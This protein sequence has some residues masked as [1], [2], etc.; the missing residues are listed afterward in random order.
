MP[1]NKQVDVP[2]EEVGKITPESDIEI[3]VSDDEV[4]EDVVVETAPPAEAEAAEPQAPKEDTLKDRLAQLEKAEE[5][6]KKLE[7]DLAVE[8]QRSQEAMRREAAARQEGQRY[9]GDA[10]EARYVAILNALDASEAEAQSAAAAWEKAEAEGDIKAKTDANRRLIRAE[11][12]ISVHEE[13]KRSYEAA[14]KE[15]EAAPP[16]VQQPE[17]PFEAALVHYPN[18]VR[19]WLRSHPEYVTD[20]KK[21]RKIATVHDDVIDDGHTFLSQD[22]F[23]VME[24]RLG[25]REAKPAPEPQEPVRQPQARRPVVS[26]APPSRDVPSAA[27]GKPT[28]SKVTLSPA[29]REIAAVSGIT[30]TEYAKQKLKLQRLKQDGHYQE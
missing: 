20:P 25:L 1:R 13:A 4:G 3:E 5:T 2:A 23:D 17:D 6:R 12:S 16:P 21:A 30:E 14:K 22:Y 8:R 27:T 24:E 18:E 29:E 28:S 10:E 9:R 19:T 26:S 7:A 15:R 11:Q